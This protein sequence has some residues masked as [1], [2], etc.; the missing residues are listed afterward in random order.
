MHLL[1]S[2]VAAFLCGTTSSLV[3]AISLTMKLRRIPEP[4]RKLCKDWGDNEL[5]SE[6]MLRLSSWA[7]E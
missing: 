1:F 7:T 4:V 3:G 5:N 2:F 6:M